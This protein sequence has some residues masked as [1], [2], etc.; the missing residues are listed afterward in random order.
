MWGDSF[1]SYPSENKEM[2]NEKQV[3]SAVLCFNVTMEKPLKQA[4]ALLTDK[5]CLDLELTPQFNT[6]EAERN[7]N[8]IFDFKFYSQLIIKE[9]NI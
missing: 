6:Q 9:Q 2:S 8:N 1:C 7:L 5:S 4:A 3:V